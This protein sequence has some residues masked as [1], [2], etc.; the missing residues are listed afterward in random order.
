VLLATEVRDLMHGDRLHWKKIQAK[1]LPE[2][3]RPWG[4]DVAEYEFIR[5]YRHLTGDER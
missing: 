1:P 4:A 3:I 2:R 5:R